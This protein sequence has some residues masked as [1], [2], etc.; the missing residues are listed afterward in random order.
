MMLLPPTVTT[1]HEF[2]ALGG[3]AEILGR[4]RVIVPLM[5]RLVVEDGGAWLLVP[6]EADYPL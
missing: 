5:P 1:L 4:R 2:A 3:A 6:D